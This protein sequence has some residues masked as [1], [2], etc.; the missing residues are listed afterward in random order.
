[1][2]KNVTDMIEH[3]VSTIKWQWAGYISS[4]LE[5]TTAGVNEFWSEDLVLV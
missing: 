3:R 2:I 4:A 1:M 5:P